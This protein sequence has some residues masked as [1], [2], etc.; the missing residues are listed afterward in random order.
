MPTDR[1]FGVADDVVTRSQNVQPGFNNV[2]SPAVGGLQ[3][4]PGGA[5]RGRRG[6]H[7]VSLIEYNAAAYVVR[8]GTG[9]MP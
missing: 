2:A 4:G 8:R 7:R 1:P 5:G 3:G 6:I 9:H